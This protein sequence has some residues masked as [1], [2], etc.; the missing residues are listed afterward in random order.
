VARGWIIVLFGLWPAVAGADPAK[1]A[2]KGRPPRVK[3][4]VTAKPV[5]ASEEHTPTL[6]AAVS[7]RATGSTVDATPHPDSPH[8]E[9]P[10][11]E[12][13]ARDVAPTDTPPPWHTVT[14]TLNPAPIAIGRYGG[15]AEVVLVAHHA[16]VVSGYVQTFPAWMLRR[17]LPSDVEV[18][19]GPPSRP[20]GE[21]GYRFYTGQRGATGLFV[22]P[23][24][25]AMPLVYPRLGPD[26]R[27]EVVSFYAYGAALDVGVQAI[28]DAG[29]TIGGG[30]GAM[31]LA[32]TPPSSVTP[33]AGVSVPTFI[34]PHVLPRVLIAA[35]WSF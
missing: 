14:L 10:H 12:P 35:G 16:I 23:S 33:P 24:A 1:P 17:L 6:P 19:G 7:P 21:L 26:L 32:Y 28:T 11:P 25:V 29:F 18:G 27:G 15:N 3:H 30:L 31:Y 34:E 4:A 22:G 5:A 13:V 20:G 2:K 8:L 9:P